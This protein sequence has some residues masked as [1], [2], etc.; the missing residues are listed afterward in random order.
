MSWNREDMYTLAIVLLWQE[1]EVENYFIGK[2]RERKV[3]GKSEIN[4]LVPYIEV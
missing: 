4:I 2:G 1:E 3:A